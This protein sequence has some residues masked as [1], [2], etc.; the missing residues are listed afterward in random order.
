MFFFIGHT[1]LYASFLFIMA[2]M[3]S[4]HTTEATEMPQSLHFFGMTG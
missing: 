2:G 4:R 1:F 3:E